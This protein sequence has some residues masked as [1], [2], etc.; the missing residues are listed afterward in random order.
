MIL[1]KIKDINNKLTDKKLIK[2]TALALVNKY[3][4]YVLYKQYFGD[5]KDYALWISYEDSLPDEAT[6]FDNLSELEEE[7]FESFTI[8]YQL[9]ESTSYKEIMQ[10]IVKDSDFIEAKGVEAFKIEYR[11]YKF[12]DKISKN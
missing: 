6:L 4:F 3:K 12:Y 11:E 10:E 1:I 8:N 2:E 5:T 9:S 7:F